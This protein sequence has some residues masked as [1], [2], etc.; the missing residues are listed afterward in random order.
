MF[1]IYSIVVPFLILLAYYLFSNP[2]PKKVNEI[3]D[4]LIKAVPNIF[5]YSFFL[6]FLERESYIKTSW[7]FYSVLFF[8]IPI[9]IIVLVLKLYYLSKA[10]KNNFRS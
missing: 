7:T 1:Y 2:K 6:Y 9:T 5:G 4:L 10:R 8:L 3:V